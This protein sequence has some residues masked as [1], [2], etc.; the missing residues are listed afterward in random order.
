MTDGKPTLDY[1]RTEPPE[2]PATW[3][4]AVF[5]VYVCLITGALAAPW[6]V[7]RNAGSDSWWWPPLLVTVGMLLCGLMMVVVPVRAKLRRPIR[8]RSVWLPIVGSSLL[9][10]LLSAAVL[11]AV[12]DAKPGSVEAWY[13]GSIAGVWLAWIITLGLVSRTSNPV[14][15][16]VRIYKAVLVGSVL[17]LLTVV[18]LHLIA[19]R[20]TECCAG[21]ASGVAIGLGVMVAI[22][23]I[24]PG[25]FFLF[26]RRWKQ[27]YGQSRWPVADGRAGPAKLETPPRGGT[28]PP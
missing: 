8:R 15:M 23:A 3:V 20:R 27:H 6:V 12:D 21:V 28:T 14:G 1:D 22:V 2:R 24:G 17:E 18:P 19:R 11:M 26:Y 10:A 25:I 16:S 9:I 7:L 4:W 13:Y 5:G